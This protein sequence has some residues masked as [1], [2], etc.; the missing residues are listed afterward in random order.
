MSRSVQFCTDDGISEA[1]LLASD[2]EAGEVDRR[3][4]ADVQLHP[5]VNVRA[6]LPTALQ[7]H[8]EHCNRYNR[9]VKFSVVVSER[10]ARS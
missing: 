3:K 5:H 6:R 9:K 10:W 1:G 4:D 7:P 8:A 2:V